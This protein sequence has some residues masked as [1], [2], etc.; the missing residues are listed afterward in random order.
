MHGRITNRLCPLAC[1]RFDHRPT[2]PAL[3][4]AGCPDGQRASQAADQV[5]MSE[6]GGTQLSVRAIDGAD[7]V[8][9]SREPFAAVRT[10]LQ[11]DLEGLVVTTAR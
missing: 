6:T 4:I 3:A 1:G 8:G 10:P 5:N 2:Y 11:F 9:T 7:A